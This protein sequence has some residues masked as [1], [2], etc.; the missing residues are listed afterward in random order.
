LA[1]WRIGKLSEKDCGDVGFKI[2]LASILLEVNRVKG[3]GK[4]T[5]LNI[6]MK[7]ETTFNFKKLLTL[8]RT[9]EEKD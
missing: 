6:I 1:S 3:E 8:K 5:D 2:G 9:H 7:K 4:I